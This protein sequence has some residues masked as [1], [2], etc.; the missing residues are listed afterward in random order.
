M[1]FGIG[2]I[3]LK[4]GFLMFRN[5]FKYSCECINNK[6]IRDKEYYE[7]INWS[8]G[9]VINKVWVVIVL[10]NRNVSNKYRYYL[11]F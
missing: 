1:E 3:I 11:N 5:Y 8:M 7:K 10:R 9:N 4:F 6:Y 2:V